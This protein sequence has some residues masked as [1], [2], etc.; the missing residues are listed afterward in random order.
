MR[1]SRC[2]EDSSRERLAAAL[3]LL[4]ELRVNGE[5]VRRAQQLQ[6]QLAHA[7]GGHRGVHV[8]ARGA[9]ELVLAGALLH[10]A[11][12]GGG[13][14]PRL[15]ALVEDRQ[16][17]PHLLAG[18][19]HVLAAHDAVG[20]ELLGPQFIHA[21]LGLDLRVHL[22]LGVS[23]LV[24]LVVAEAAIADQVDQH[25]VAELLAEGERQAARRSCRPARRRRSHG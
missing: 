11:V 6:P 16:V 13:G 14:D 24:R 15:Q 21:L 23:G 7:R 5:P 1:A 22:R 20:D 4:D 19:L 3:Q 18:P 10:G 25:V 17:V 2:G 8:G 12:L 9:V